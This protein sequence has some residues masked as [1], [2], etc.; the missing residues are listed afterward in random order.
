MVGHALQV[1][2]KPQLAASSLVA[3][4]ERLNKALVVGSFCMNDFFR[5][6]LVVL[7]AAWLSALF[8]SLL[9]TLASVAG[10]LLSKYSAAPAV[11]AVDWWVKHVVLPLLRRQTWLGRAAVIFVNNIAILA[12]LIALGRWPGASM[13]A[14]VVV[15]L[16]L[17]IAF[18]LLLD[19]TDD[20]LAPRL[21]LAPAER[22]KVQIGMT[23][24]MLEPP[25]IM[26]AL[27]LSF[28][29]WVAG[30]SFAAAWLTF[31][32]W[33]LPAMLLA[34]AG[35]GLWLGAGRQGP[36]LPTQDP[37]EKDDFGPPHN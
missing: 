8:G 1:R 20:T 25:A 15:G 34:A 31:F 10:W 3:L 22:R 17:G 37:A 30:I 14:V 7:D 27:G 5:T 35:E 6:S 24:N 32:I 28:G 9:L 2:A 23:L 33:V 21:Q 19:T 18:R 4:A 29:Q 12:A 11:R 16:S 26:L 13:L 36:P